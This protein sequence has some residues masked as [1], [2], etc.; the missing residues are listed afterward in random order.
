MCVAYPHCVQLQPSIQP[1]SD[2]RHSAW[3]QKREA[4]ILGGH[5]EHEYL[6]LKASDVLWGHIDETY[7]L[8]VKQFIL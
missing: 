6:R 4:S 5:A 3:C 8:A 1:S 7:Y 2:V